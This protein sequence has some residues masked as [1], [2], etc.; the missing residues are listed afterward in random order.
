MSADIQS[1]FGTAVRARRKHLGF[2]QEEL[3]ERAS[4]HRT[5][6]ADVERGAR[7]LSLASIEK[8]ACALDVSIPV[9]FYH[10]GGNG[11]EPADGAVDILLVEDDADDAERTLKAF[12]TANLTNRVH[13]AR[14]GEEALE[15]IFCTGRHSRRRIEDRPHVILLELKLPGMKG[16]QVLRQIKG[17]HQTRAI[18]VVILTGSH[19]RRQDVAECLKLG[20]NACL[21]KPVDFCRFSEVIPQLDFYWTLRKPD[22]NSTRPLN[23]P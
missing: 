9:L 10:A 8:L 12:E 20:A 2:S 11:N 23:A 4:L 22:S 17:N 19:Q 18:P 7:N 6:V 15:F 3:A 5:Y 14:D 1:R 21:M 16:I 13:V